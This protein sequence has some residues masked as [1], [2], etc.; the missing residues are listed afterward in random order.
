MLDDQTCLVTGS[1][2]G[3]GRAV[4]EELGRNGADVVVNYRSSVDEAESVVDAIEDEG[5]T[6]I[7]VQGNVADY[8]EVEAMCSEVHDTFGSVDV[9]VNNAGITVDKKFEN[10]TRD[11]WQRV[12][13]VNL[14]GVF[15]CTHCLFDDIKSAEDGRL[16]NISSVVGQQ[17]NY[18]QANY[19]TTKSGL[20]GFTRT[21][22]LELASTGSTANCVAP[23]FV[24]TDMLET[25]PERVQ[26]KI[27]QRIPLD[28]FATPEDVAGIVRFV[29]SEDA[30]Y[31]TGQILAVNGGM[32]W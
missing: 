2:R 19:A 13:D 26:E 32:E 24:K 6:A 7:A 1:S 12:L 22:A 21:L 11:D 14:G 28:R 16:I 9:L 17:G 20:F 18:G 31:M 4:A 23:G 3:I 30:G 25:V 15:N 27:L 5:G 8:D 10:M 29:A